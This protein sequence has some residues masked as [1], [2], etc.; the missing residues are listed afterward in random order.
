MANVLDKA[1]K[2][3]LLSWI[4]EGL[5]A[6][7]INKRAAKFKPPFT[8]S[9]QQIQYYRKTRENR[10]TEIKNSTEDMALK[11]GWALKVARVQALGTMLDDLL[12]DW[13]NRDWWLDQVK[14][15]GSRENYERIEYREFNK[16]LVDAI[17]DLYADIAAEMGDRKNVQI[18]N[19][20]NFDMEAWKQQTKKR[21]EEISQMEDA[22]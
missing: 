2:E 8:V 12:R 13:D 21:L 22:D 6:D 19:N 16:A 3:A 7:E 17:R 15:I 9:R 1:Q 14:G 10:F 4:A 20:F 18:E 11:S 5:N